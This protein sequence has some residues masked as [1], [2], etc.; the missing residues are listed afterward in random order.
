MCPINL[1]LFL[2]PMEFYI[3]SRVLISLSKMVLLRENTD[4]LWTLDCLS[5]P[6]LSF[7]LPFE[8]MPSSLLFFLLIVFSTHVLYNDSPYNKLFQCSLDYSHL[9]SFGCVCYPL[10][11]PYSSHKLAFR[12][13]MCLFLG[14]SSHHKGYRCYDPISK[15][16]YQS[17]HVVFDEKK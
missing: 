13:K 4:T 15:K 10:H 16:V 7:L 17:C 3:A 1:F 2:L 6:N 11:C 9:R 5:L 12:S 14:Y 8:L